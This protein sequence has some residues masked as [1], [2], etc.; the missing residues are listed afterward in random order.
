MI[1][2]RTF[3][4]VVL[5][6]AMAF[7]AAADGVKQIPARVESHPIQTLTLSDQQFLLG[8]K[9]GKPATIS[10]ELRIARGQ[11]RLPVVVLMHG[12]EGGIDHPNLWSDE[13]NAMGISTFAVDSFTGRGIVNLISDQ[14]Q[15]DRLTVIV[16]AY[17]ALGLLARHPRVDPGRIVLMGFSFGGQIAL[18]AN[19]KRSQRMWNDSGAEFA[20]FIPFYAS[21]V[22]T[23]ISDTDTADRPIRMFHGVADDYVP[24]APCR[25]YV[26]RLKQAGRDVQL[27]EYANAIHAFDYVQLDSNVLLPGA[28]VGNYCTVREDPMGIMVNNETGKPFAWT[29]SCVRIGAHAGYDGAAAAAAHKEVDEFLRT[30]FKLK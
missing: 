3:A 16:D 19:L 24:V 8:D 4:A 15:F 10:G 18:Y 11:G 5:A 27:T 12:A 7:P 6:C 13:L 2:C 23:Y 20:A 30:I 9:N 17:R 21:C 26:E 28:Q 29:D 1:D 25:A 22:R 14:T